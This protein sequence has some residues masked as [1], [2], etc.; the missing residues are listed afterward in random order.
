MTTKHLNVY[1]LGKRWSLAPKTLDRWRQR[2]VGPRF[3][4]IGGHIIYRL[5]DAEAYEDVRLRQM[6]EKDRG[7][8][9]SENVRQG[10]IPSD[11]VALRP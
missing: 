8:W 5:S 9:I 1:E 11:S 2:G 7:I 6:T 4:K 10:A 3:L